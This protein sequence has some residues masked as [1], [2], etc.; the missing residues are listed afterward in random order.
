MLLMMETLWKQKQ[1]Q[2]ANGNFGYVTYDYEN[3]Y[4]R[5]ERQQTMA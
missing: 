4:Y 5:P 3:F 1:Q 2:L